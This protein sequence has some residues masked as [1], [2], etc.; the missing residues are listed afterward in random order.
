LNNY[1]K[2]LAAICNINK[3]FSSHD[4]RRIFGTTVTLS[5]GVPLE[6]VSSMLGHT[7]T[8]MTQKYAKIVNQKL[9]DDMNQLEQKFNDKE[10]R[11]V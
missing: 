11:S 5:N 8:I 3:E 7:N 9:L 10:N 6:S 1:L 4:G 2:E